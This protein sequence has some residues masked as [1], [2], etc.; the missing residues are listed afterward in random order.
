[1]SDAASQPRF[2]LK[3][4]MRLSPQVR[5]VLAAAVHTLNGDPKKAVVVTVP[6][7][8]FVPLEFFERSRLDSQSVLRAVGDAAMT[9]GSVS[10]RRASAVEHEVDGKAQMGFVLL[11]AFVDGFDP[12]DFASPP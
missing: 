6:A 5:D 12:A 1:M 2:S 11:P 10:G 8:I 7:G 4:P 3:A 9:V